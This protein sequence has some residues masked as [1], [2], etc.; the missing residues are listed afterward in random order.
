[1]LPACGEDT[2]PAVGRDS[3]R[4]PRSEATSWLGYVVACI[5]APPKDTVS[6]SDLRT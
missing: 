2:G 5:A 1:M 4:V 3:S 6:H